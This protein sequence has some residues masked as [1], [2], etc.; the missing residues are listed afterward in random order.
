MGTELQALTVYAL[1]PDGPT[2]LLR[3]DYVKYGIV[4]LDENQME[5]LVVLRSLPDG[6]GCA[7]YYVWQ[8]WGLVSRSMHGCP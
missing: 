1:R 4:D 3:T 2:E 8:G 5:D 7:E 6:E